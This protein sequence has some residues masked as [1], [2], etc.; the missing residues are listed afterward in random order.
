MRQ[1]LKACPCIVKNNY[2]LAFEHPDGGYQLPKG[3]VEDEESVEAAVLREL[4]EESGISTARIIERVGEMDW[5]VEAGTTTYTVG[6]H[7][8]WHI[9]LLDAGKDLPENWSHAATGSDVEEG[10]IFKYFWQSLDQ[11]SERFHPV[12]RQVLEMVSEHISRNTSL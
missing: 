3:T 10:Q 2:I 12:Y 4:E 7:Q 9:Y 6:E 8:Q 5:Y 1:V 11:I